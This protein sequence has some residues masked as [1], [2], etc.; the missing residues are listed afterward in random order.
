[1]LLRTVF[2]PLF[3]FLTI[4]RAQLT[5]GTV[6]NSE[7]DT[8][9]NNLL[10]EWNSPAGLSIAVVRRD[11]SSED[12][13][14]VETRGYGNAKADGSK[15]T[16]DTLF[17]LGSDS[18]LFDTLATGLLISNK[19]LN[20]PI[21]WTTKIGSIIPEWELMDPIASNLTSIIDLMSHRTGLPRHD[22]SLS[23][24]KTNLDLIKHLKYLRPS[25]EFRETFQ[26]C[27]LGYIV[28]SYLPTALLPGNPSLAAYRANA[29][30]NLADGFAREGDSTMNPINTTGTH[31]IPFWLQTGGDDGETSAYSLPL[32]VTWL[33]VL[34]SNGVNPAT[35]ETVIPTDVL[36]MVT[37]GISVWPFS[38]D[39][40]GETFPELS[41][42]TYGGGQYRATYRGHGDI[43]GFNSLITRFP[44]EGAGVVVLSNDN[45]DMV[46]VVRYRIFD[47]LFDL[48]PP[49][50]W[51]SRVE[52]LYVGTAEAVSEAVSTHRS[53]NATPPTGGFEK[54]VGNYTNLGY[55]S[56]EL[57]QIVPTPVSASD[58]CTELAA[59]MNST[60]SAFVDPAVPM[61]ALTWDLGASQYVKLAHFDGDVF[62]VTGWSGKPT[63]NPSS[64]LWAFDAGFAGT[65]VEFGVGADGNVGF[66]FQGGIWG[67][68][69]NVPDPNGDT[70]EERAEIWF[71]GP[72]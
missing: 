37:S 3:L 52:Q 61:F 50:D 18:K 7:I 58:G 1:M 33:K 53:V 6:L 36:N 29:S 8:F 47:Q 42:A 19:S 5:N 62:N 35:N 9:I 14:N 64:P 65:I 15:I 69:V 21:D 25:T 54:L 2:G 24:N 20:T 60:W 55:T 12:G 16:A 27:N 28:L 71:T 63:G 44:N 38:T 46:D 22:L 59:T 66:G 57:C 68:G 48:E 51:K 26:Y 56:F 17:A 70:A 34:L 39:G 30:G 49:V 11:A 67:A 4:S 31:A 43:Y 32:I 41:V 40:N 10:T 45:L 13:W 23:A 72:P